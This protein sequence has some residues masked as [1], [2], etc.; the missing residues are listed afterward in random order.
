MRE[1]LWRSKWGLT[2][3]LDI[4]GWRPLDLEDLL[5]PFR[6]QTVWRSEDSGDFWQVN[7]WWLPSDEGPGGRAWYLYLEKFSDSV[8]MLDWVLDGE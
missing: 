1:G 3:K 5:C 6:G 2:V 8:N 7:G 4:T